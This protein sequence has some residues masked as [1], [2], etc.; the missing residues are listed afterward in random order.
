VLEEMD[1]LRGLTTALRVLGGV[2]AGLGDLDEA[3]EVLRRGH[4]LAERIG[5]I[6]EQAGCLVNLGLV[7]QERKDYDRAI[8]HDLRAAELLE[9]IGHMTGLAGCLAN[10]AEKT[11]EADR[12]DD[13]LVYGDRA[14]DV[15]R[16]LDGEPLVY[17]ADALY[18]QAEVHLKRGQVEEAA[19]EAEEAA[20]LFAD[21]GDEKDV[22]KAEA[23]V[24]KAKASRPVSERR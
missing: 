11:M 16:A 24:A 8:A 15:A 2:H 4:A 5:A 20:R 18:V 10:L 14:V 17:L 23:I 22:E 12:F 6:E 13:A 19:Q 3:T 21:S 7:E 1:D 9:S